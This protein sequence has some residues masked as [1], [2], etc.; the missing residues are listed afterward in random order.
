[1]DSNKTSD[2]LA[3][4]FFGLIASMAMIYVTNSGTPLY[5]FGYELS[6]DIEDFGI[7]LFRISEIFLAIISLRWAYRMCKNYYPVLQKMRSKV[8]TP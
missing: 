5:H 4:G 6:Y 1:M 2:M 3:L 8:K 7:M